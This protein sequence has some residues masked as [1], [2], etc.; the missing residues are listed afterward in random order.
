MTPRETFAYIEA[1]QKNLVRDQKMRVWQS[2]HI[3]AL[4][5]SKRLPRFETL[6]PKP[7]K[8]LND[9]EKQEK[10]VEFDDMKRKFGL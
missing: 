10:R 5:R 7:A 1:Y 8:K 4:M 9:L 6:L 2:W 3:A